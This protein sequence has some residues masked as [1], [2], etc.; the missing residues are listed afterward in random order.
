MKNLLVS[1]FSL[2]FLIFVLASCGDDD[3]ESTTTP[4]NIVG[5]WNVTSEVFSGC[6]DQ[7]DNT[8]E[9]YACDANECYS[10]T[11][12][13]TQRVRILYVLEDETLID[14]NGT[15]SLSGNTMNLCLDGSCE[16][17]TFSGDETTLT[18]SGNDEFGCDFVLTLM[19]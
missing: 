17:I 19:K 1:L 9:T 12:T 15:Y 18:L 10:I 11:F 6:D 5:I 16:D 2:V 8:T 3:G 14:L 13:T 7:S 4:P